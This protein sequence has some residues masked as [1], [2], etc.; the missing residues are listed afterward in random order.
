MLQQPP[1][2]NLPI[3]D[4][5]HQ[6]IPSEQSFPLKRIVNEKTD[7]LCKTAESHQNVKCQVITM[8]E[9]NIAFCR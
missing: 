8:D 4:F 9:D 3:I 6:V 7:K 2:K 5:A 1:P